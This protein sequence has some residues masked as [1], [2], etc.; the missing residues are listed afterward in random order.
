L[1]F[2]AVC[3]ANEFVAL[4]IGYIYLSIPQFESL[5]KIGTNQL[6][7]F[8]G[9]FAASISHAPAASAVRAVTPAAAAGIWKTDT[10]ARAAARPATRATW[11]STLPCFRLPG[12]L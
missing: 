5:R 12:L 10:H 2:P 9:G 11:S 4:V 3:V 8:F 1:N 6:P 7:H